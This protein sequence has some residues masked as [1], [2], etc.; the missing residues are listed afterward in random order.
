YYTEQQAENAFLGRSA[1]YITRESAGDLP[2]AIKA[3]FDSVVLFR[4]LPS[5]GDDARPLYIYL[6]LV[7]QT[8]P[9]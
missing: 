9:L 8:L 7:Y 4:K 2:Q 3:A 5:A 1:L 6:C